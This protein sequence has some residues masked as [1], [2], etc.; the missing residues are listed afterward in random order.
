MR[1]KNII[2]SIGKFVLN[3]IFLLTVLFIAL[4]LY[5]GRALYQIQIL[6]ADLYK[7]KIYKNTEDTATI[8]G[9]RGNIYDRYGR[10]LAVNEKAQSLYFQLDTSSD[11]LNEAYWHLMEILENK[12]DS[13]SLDVEFPILYDNDN[14]FRFTDSYLDPNRK[15]ALGNFLA[16]VYN[17][18]RKDLTE[19]QW[20][21]SAEEVY[22]YMRDTTYTVDPSY[23][24][25]AALQILAFRHAIFVEKWDGKTSLLI[26]SNISQ[27]TEVSIQEMRGDF[28]GF[29]VE[30]VYSRVYPEKELFAHILG[31]VGR[32]SDKEQLEELQQQGYD[33]KDLIGKT[34]LE[35]VYESELRGENGIV[36]IELDGKTNQ[37][38]SETVVKEATRGNDLFITI[39]R[40]LQEKCYDILY[41]Q[42]KSLLL[43]KITGVYVENKTYSLEDIYC[44]MIDNSFV[45]IADV[46]TSESSYAA[47]LKALYDSKAEGILETMRDLLL[48]SDTVTGDYSDEITSYYNVIIEG[49]RDRKKTLSSAYRDANSKFYVSYSYEGNKTARE[50][51][52]YCVQNDYIDREYYNLGKEENMDLI[53]ETIVN[54]EIEY[55]RTNPEFKKTVYTYIL[56]NNQ[57]SDADFMMLLYDLGY[58]SNED[59]SLE[60][61]QNARMSQS[62][63]LANVKQKI[64]NDEITPAQLNLDPCSG[65]IVITDCNSGEVLAMV[66]YP[67]YDNN[68]VLNSWSY[69]SKIA[70]DKSSPLTF[71][72][73]TETRAP[74]STFKMVTALAG[75]ELGYIDKNYTVYDRYQYPNVNSVQKPVCWSRNSHGLV[76]VVRGLDVSCNYFFYDL[77][78]RL[79]DPDPLT[80]AFRDAVGYEKLDTYATM[81]G[82]A[83]KTN[84]E[85]AEA[86]PT[87]STL[88]AVRSAIGQGTHSYTTANINRY[89]CTLANGGTVYNLYLVDRVQTAS[90]EVLSKTEPVV[91]N[92]ADVSQENLALVREGMRLVSTDS[93]KRVLSVLEEQGITT[94]GKTGTAQESDNRP[95]HSLF[96]GFASYENPEIVATIVIPYGGGSTNATPAFRD[97]IAAYYDLDLSGE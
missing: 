16:E 22:W 57:F 4:F 18:S 10:P 46:E 83:T 44:A 5:L 36:N 40:D 35:S 70:E 87:V 14:G 8:Q 74:G 15:T 73:L 47:N 96:T 93:S 49:M 12:G 51:L 62:S 45:A 61:M 97:V 60:Q 28:P 89:T 65:S 71:R 50:F 54:E 9:V 20:N 55:A 80:G 32:I 1:L 37:R 76:N 53:L 26:A 11:G 24:T 23:T 21:A 92:V 17:T 69:Y 72:A 56:K 27:G 2:R 84:I 48:N 85:L 19:E 64:S 78:Y 34:G 25:E 95:D 38:I 29:T 68:L 91:D 43:D 41:N 79:S 7:E 58:L 94:A 77:G 52:E 90:G 33:E 88:D 75:L 13:L 63:M 67:S 81:L 39:D 66:S 42:I 82:L 31:Y 6:D 86:T 3:R 59:G 30:T